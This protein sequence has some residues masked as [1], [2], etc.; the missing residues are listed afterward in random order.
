MARLTRTKKG[1]KTAKADPKAAKQSKATATRQAGQS[2]GTSPAVRAVPAPEKEKRKKKDH[3]HLLQEHGDK[4]WDF[5]IRF[6]DYVAQPSVHRSFKMLSPS[7]HRKTALTA[8]F[9]LLS[10][11]NVIW[12]NDTFDKN[13]NALKSHYEKVLQAHGAHE[14]HFEPRLPIMHRN[15][16]PSGTSS[17]PV[18]VFIV[19]IGH[20]KRRHLKVQ[21]W[22]DG[23]IWGGRD[24]RKVTWQS[25]GAKQNM[26]DQIN[27]IMTEAIIGK[28]KVF[29][30]REVEGKGCRW[31]SRGIGEDGF[32]QQ[33]NGKNKQC[34]V[35]ALRR[36]K[37][38]S[39][40]VTEDDW[41]NIWKDVNE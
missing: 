10:R 39:Q 6:D 41:K 28:K 13:Y 1:R 23:K 3:S 21:V 8:A 17:R 15:N 35:S 2:K 26:T 38:G 29:K 33:C 40:S 34:L 7:T 9:E 36:S 24:G 11:L 37:K 12:S 20:Y 19:S 14:A 16:E 22:R 25:D 5:H 4:N 27:K 30:C 18:V 32:E 31:G